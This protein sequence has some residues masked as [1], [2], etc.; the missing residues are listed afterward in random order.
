M[1]SAVFGS[2]AAPSSVTVVTYHK[3]WSY[4]FNVFDCNSAGELEPYPGVPPSAKHVAAL[5]HSLQKSSQSTI[6]LAANYFPKAS[7]TAFSKQLDAPLYFLSANVGED[8]VSSYIELFDYLVQ[9][10]TQ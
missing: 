7:I 1:A 8:G 5:K 3:V 6:V 4:F 2:A 9:N 10:L